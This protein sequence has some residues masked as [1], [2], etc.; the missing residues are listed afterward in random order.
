MGRRGFLALTARKGVKQSP[1]GG[2][3]WHEVGP[4]W[5]RTRLPEPDGLSVRRTSKPG[6]SERWTRECRIYIPDFYQT[7]AHPRGAVGA[8]AGRFGCLL[9]VCAARAPGVTLLGGHEMTRTGRAFG[10]SSGQ[11]LRDACRPA[12]LGDCDAQHWRCLLPRGQ[13]TGMRARRARHHRIRTSHRAATIA[14]LLG[15]AR[16]RPMRGAGRGGRPR[17]RRRSGRSGARCRSWSGRSRF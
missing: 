7:R 11:L 17:R 3:L 2:R 16:P 1:D 13:V 9:R 5:L 6:S 8:R 15:S 10:G 12:G 14:H 4:R